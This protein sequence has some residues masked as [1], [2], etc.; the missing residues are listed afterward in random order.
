MARPVG[1]ADVSS[2]GLQTPADDPE[3]VKSTENG[4]NGKAS[5]FIHDEHNDTHTRSSSRQAYDNSGFDTKL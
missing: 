1:V 4:K 5:F 3:P 2:S